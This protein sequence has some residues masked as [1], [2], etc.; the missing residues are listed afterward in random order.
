MDFEP[1]MQNLHTCI[2]DVSGSLTSSLKMFKRL[3]EFLVKNRRH[4]RANKGSYERV[5]G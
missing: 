1:T 2:K 4:M 3:P 5:I